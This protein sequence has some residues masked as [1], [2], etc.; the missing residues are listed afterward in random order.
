MTSYWST[1]LRGE[2]KKKFL[3]EEIKRREKKLKEKSNEKNYASKQ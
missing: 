1:Y 2:K 3:K